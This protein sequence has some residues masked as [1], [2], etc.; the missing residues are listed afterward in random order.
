MW[1]MYE[2]NGTTSRGGERQISSQFSTFLTVKLSIRFH[3]SY[4]NSN[5]EWL[6]LLYMSYERFKLW[7]QQ[8]LENVL[9]SIHHQHSLLFTLN[10]ADFFFLYST[11][12]KFNIFFVFTAL[13]AHTCYVWFPPDNED[14][15]KTPDLFPVFHVLNR[16]IRL[17]CV[18]MNE[19]EC[20]YVVRCS[21]QVVCWRC[22]LR[23]DKGSWKKMWKKSR[24]ESLEGWGL[25]KDPLDSSHHHV[26]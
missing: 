4:V 21:M 1:K 12:W 9:F 5:S 8:P 19:H 2:K 16:E 17:F 24:V 23:Q 6:N 26:K 14:E 10:P 22:W 7:I 3:G 25:L 20:E 13:P 11:L 18:E 15:R